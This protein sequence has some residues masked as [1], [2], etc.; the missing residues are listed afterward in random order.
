MN[1]LSWPFRL[2]L[3]MACLGSLS[4]WLLSP[5]A[6]AASLPLTTDILPSGVPLPSPA[7]D[8]SIPP[9]DYSTELLGDVH[10][11]RTW[12]T[13]QGVRITLQDVEEVWGLASG[14]LQTGA[15]YDGMTAI[16]A[17]L[18][19][20]Q[21]FGWPGGLFNVSA[22]QIRGRSFTAERLGALNTVSGYDAGRSTR[23]F[24]IWYG[25]SFFNNHLDIRGGSID[26]DTEFLVSQN[27]SFFLNSSFGWP[28]STSS[29]L[30]S[31][32][33][34]WPLS[35]VGVRA[36]WTPAAP[37]VLMGAITN[38]NPTRGPFYSS[39]SATERDPSGTFFSTHGGTLVMGEAQ[40]Y[41][42]LAKRLAGD[43]APALPGTWKIGG[44]YDS[45]RFPSQRY[46]N[47]GTLL[48]SPDS[49]GTPRYHPGNW[50]AYAVL[51]QMI[52]R[53]EKNSGKTINF[54]FR[55]SVANQKR[56]YF[57]LELQSGLTFDELIPGRPDDTIGI[58][59]GTS[60]YSKSAL[61][62]AEDSVRFGTKE[63]YVLKPEHHIELTYQAAVTPY[64]IV[65]P[66]F[67]YFFN[68]GGTISP[69]NTTLPHRRSAV[70]GVNMT[71]TF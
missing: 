41:L 39:V 56:S 40:L 37:L 42:D 8:F 60:L 66:D 19:T 12:L 21:A 9:E 52:W 23:L 71:T 51:D 58:A 26:L 5:C 70:L 53:K 64:L 62:N 43:D 35:A 38:D 67:Q 20:Q 46:D 17:S 7:P 54:F 15:T 3:F 63:P 13:R 30:Y 65:Q 11:L 61:K 44:L 22:L 69:A 49:T 16:A 50:M 45:G 57:S 28:L 6:S 47:H 31:G 25:Q 55:T 24:E 29:N 34:S 59:W 68:T 14:G 1:V 48:A 32:G 27:A 4:A 2:S 36:K 18:N 10:G 33:P